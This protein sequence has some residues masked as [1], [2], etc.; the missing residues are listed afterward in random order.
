[1]N[2]IAVA[3]IVKVKIITADGSSLIYD[4]GT[5]AA[6]TPMTITG[7]QLNGAVTAA[8]KSVSATTGFPAIVTIALYEDD[9]FCTTNYVDSLGVKSVPVKTVK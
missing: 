1:M 3:T 4:A 2:P 8:G 5:I 6:G 7:A 9:V